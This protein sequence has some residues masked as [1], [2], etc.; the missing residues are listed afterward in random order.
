MGVDAEKVLRAVRRRSLADSALFQST[1]APKNANRIEARES[2]SRE[3]FELPI[4][5]NDL[6][7]PT[8]P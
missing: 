5:I 3:I 4:L 1:S 8:V 2:T 6:G 7:D